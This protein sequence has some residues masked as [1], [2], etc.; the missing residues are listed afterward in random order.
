MP[1]QEKSYS[2][3]PDWE[4]AG[5]TE[6]EIPKNFEEEKNIVQDGSKFTSTEK[7]GLCGAMLLGPIAFGGAVWKNPSLH[8]WCQDNIWLYVLCMVMQVL[9]TYKFTS[10]PRMSPRT[11]YMYLG[12]IMCESYLL[13]FTVADV[14]LR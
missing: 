8:A 10:M 3:I 5:A 6:L 12:I 13:G 11:L 2:Q 14:W 4:K 7:W 1:I 9:L